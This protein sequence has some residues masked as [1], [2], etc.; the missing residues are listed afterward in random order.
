MTDHQLA[1]I[2]DVAAFCGVSK[3]T[4]HTWL[5][6]GTAPKSYKIG[7]Y[8]RFKWSDVE[9]WLA[10]HSDDRQPDAAA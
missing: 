10:D 1:S 4:V 3:A 9:A 6:H 7:K 2:D 8:R 5:Y